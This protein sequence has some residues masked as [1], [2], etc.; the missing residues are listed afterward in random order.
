VGMQVDQSGEHGEAAEIDDVASDS[1]ATVPAGPTSM[2]TPSPISTVASGCGSSFG[3]V[4]TVGTDEG[5]SASL[6]RTCRIQRRE[7]EDHTAG[8]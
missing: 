8:S 1:T 5:E 3:Q 2:I 7:I 6:R 4:S